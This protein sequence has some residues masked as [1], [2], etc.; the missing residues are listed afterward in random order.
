V[1]VNREF[2]YLPLAD[3]EFLRI[4]QALERISTAV[5]ADVT[6]LAI[7][8]AA[9]AAASAL[10]AEGYAVGEQDGTAVESGTYFHYNAKY[11]ADNCASMI[12]A[13]LDDIQDA[14]DR[15]DEAIENLEKEAGYAWFDVDQNDGNMYV[16]VIQAID[17]DVSFSVNENTGELIVTIH[18]Q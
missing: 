11:F 18:Q 10:K 1:S 6:A 9:E 8:K 7:Q 3:P 13:Q 4:A 14:I 5:G 15:A 17:D 12:N 16:T 2:G